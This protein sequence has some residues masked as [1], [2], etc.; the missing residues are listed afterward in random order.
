MFKIEI[1]GD[2]F[3]YAIDFL[4]YAKLSFE[5]F[6]SYLNRFQARFK[7]VSGIFNVISI[8]VFVDV[9]SDAGPV[10]SNCC[11]SFRMPIMKMQ[12]M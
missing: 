1:F 8:G 4:D 5:L 3:D 7:G 6:V 10:L 11:V 12:F 2:T 9:W